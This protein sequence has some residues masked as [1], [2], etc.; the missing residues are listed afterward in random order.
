M[1]HG[2]SQG[3]VNS[4]PLETFVDFCIEATY[5]VQNTK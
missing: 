5:D 4:L 1:K 3:T 2:T